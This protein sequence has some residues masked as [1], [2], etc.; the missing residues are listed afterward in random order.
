MRFPSYRRL[1]VLGSTLAIGIGAFAIPASASA[2]T[3]SPDTWVQSKTSDGAVV[4]MADGHVWSVEAI[5]RINTM[6]WLPVDNITYLAD[7][8][9]KCVSATTTTF[10]LLNTDESKSKGGEQVCAQVLK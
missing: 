1:A 9:G 10:I 5:D 6:L 4:T 8:Q 3:L 2:S 7:R